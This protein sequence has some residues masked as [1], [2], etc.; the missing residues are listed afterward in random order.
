MVHFMASQPMIPDLANSLPTTYTFHPNNQADDLSTQQQAPPSSSQPSTN[1]NQSSPNGPIRSSGTH[2]GDYESRLRC[3]QCETWVVNLSDHLRKTHRIALPIDRKPLLRRAREEKRRMAESN[4]QQQLNTVAPPPRA[5]Q[6]QNIVNGLPTLNSHQPHNEIENLLFKQENDNSILQHSVQHQFALPENILNC[7]P[8]NVTNIAGGQQQYTTIKRRRSSDDDDHH[9]QNNNNSSNNTNGLLLVVTSSSPNKKQRT[10]IVD[11]KMQHQQKQGKKGRNKNMN[12]TNS[13]TQQQHQQDEPS[14]DLTKVIQ[15]LTNEMTFLNQHLQTTSLLLQKQLDLARD[16]LHAC[17]VQFAHFLFNM[18]LAVAS[19][20]TTSPSVTSSSSLLASKKSG[21]TTPGIKIELAKTYQF[22]V[23]LEDVDRLLEMR[24]KFYKRESDRKLL[25]L[26]IPLISETDDNNLSADQLYGSSTTK[27]SIKHRDLEWLYVILPYVKLYNPHCGLCASTKNY[28][29][30]L[31][32]AQSYLL[33]VYF[34]CQANNCG[35]PFQSIVTVKD[36]GKALLCTRSS[37]GHI[38]DHSKAKRVMRPNRAVGRAVQERKRE[39]QN[40]TTEHN[41]IIDEWNQSVFND[42]SDF[43]NTYHL[44]TTTSTVNN[45]TSL[46]SIEGDFEETNRTSS[47]KRFVNMCFDLTQLAATLRTEINQNGLLVGAIQTISMSPFYFT[48]HTESS[49]RYYHSQLT[50]KHQPKTQLPPVTQLTIPPSTSS[51]IIIIDNGA[52]HTTTQPSQSC[53]QSIACMICEV[54]EHNGKKLHYYELMLTNNDDTS[55]IPITLTYADGDDSFTPSNEVE[56]SFWLKRFLWDHEQLHKSSLPQNIQDYYFPQPSV[57]LVNSHRDNVLNNV[58]LEFF[59]QENFKEYLQRTYVCLIN[60]LPQDSLPRIYAKKNNNKNDGKILVQEQLPSQPKTILFVSST[61]ILYE[62]RLLVMKHVSS[63]LRQ[64]ALWSSLLLLHTNNWND[65]KLSWSLICEIF[66]NW[67]TNYVSLKSYELL[68]NKVAKIEND[69]DIMSG[70]N[71]VYDTM[72]NSNETKSEQFDEIDN[73]NDEEEEENKNSTNE[74]DLSDFQNDHFYTN[75]MFHSGSNIFVSPYE[76]DLRKIFNE[77]NKSKPA[78]LAS[79]DS[80]SNTDKI[81]L[82][83]IKGNYKWLHSLLKEYIPTLPLWS[84]L[85][86]SI[87]NNHK[88]VR[89]NKRIQRIMASKDR[90]LNNIKRIQLAEK[91]HGKTDLVV[92]RLAKDMVNIVSIADTRNI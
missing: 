43:N 57:L 25:K 79:F 80:L 49:I 54:V 28:G 42:T 5:T 71:N 33:R 31:D 14:D 6:T 89:L 23:D 84:N 24:Q 45:N 78:L 87:S 32:T 65:I 8:M 27:T 38:V 83:K 59:N 18:A 22:D 55:F 9:T 68:C 16:S 66:L 74:I 4:N 53:E 47:T 63:E 40:E 77:K 35:C 21:S 41:N 70:Y 10:Q 85:I 39:Q 61:T 82:K 29:R 73:E 56:L 62:F 52:F 58:C 90:R 7:P 37:N 1:N 86:H 91:V 76:T 60:R 36:N 20:S 34:Y 50:R 81:I 15:M 11:G 72:E 17:S 19:S 48:L 26:G 92:E 12:N 46:I 3:P 64:L 88:T 51:Q 44:T 30:R 75:K 69:P 67:G 2:P 13:K